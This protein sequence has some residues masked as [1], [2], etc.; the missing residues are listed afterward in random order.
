M[1]AAGALYR[2]QSAMLAWLLHGDTGI[3]AG[4]HTPSRHGENASARLRIYA[5]AYRLRL[6]EVLGNDFPTTRA[7][8][9]DAAFEALALAYLAAHPSTQPSARHFGHAFAGWLAR[10][11]DVPPGLH[12][13]AGFEWL[14]G[15]AF[16]AADREPLGIADIAAVPPEAWP[17]LQFRWHP[18]L[19]LIALAGNAPS[20][21][22]A[23][24]RGTPVPA[25]RDVT[26]STW[27]LWRRDHEVHWRQ[28][29][30]DEASVL[31]ALG[32]GSHFGQ[33]CGQLN[34][35]HGDAGALRAASLLKRWLV[36]GLLTTH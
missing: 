16:D 27:L 10:Q 30:A 17:T 7:A 2:T 35:R 29:D 25:W 20:Q 14:Q 23:C 34:D 36:D 8:V 6:V 33:L 9:G 12:P 18:S 31:R 15:E 11:D 1:S 24:A 13:L 26:A 32:D 28:L 22:E 4:I 21:V 3:A 19:R 5:D